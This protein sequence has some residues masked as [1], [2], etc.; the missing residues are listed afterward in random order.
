MS[1]TQDRSDQLVRSFMTEK[2]QFAP[3]LVSNMK[4][5]YVNRLPRRTNESNV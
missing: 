5:A 2:L 1:E 3:A 4:F